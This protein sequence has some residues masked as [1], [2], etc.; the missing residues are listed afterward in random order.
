M[1][2]DTTI[3]LHMLGLPR[4]ALGRSFQLRGRTHT[5]TGCA[6]NKVIAER[7]DGKPVRL[8]ASEVALLMHHEDLAKAIA[9]SRGNA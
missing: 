4:D 2:T 3:A 5:V 9:R 1:T 6:K 7:D 8:P